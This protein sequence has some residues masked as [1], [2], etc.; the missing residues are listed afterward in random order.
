MRVASSSVL[1]LAAASFA[2]SVA[3]AQ[4]TPPA[5]GGQAPF[6]VPPY[7]NLK[8][9]PQ[10]ITRP[11]LLSNM[12][13]FSQSL[14]VR[15]TYCHVGQEGAPLSTFDFASDAKQHKLIAREMLRMAHRLNTD[16]PGITGDPSAKISCYTCHRGSEKPVSEIPPGT[17]TVPPPPGAAPPPPPAQPAKSERGSA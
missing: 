4:T 5:P 14:G 8:I 10:D 1:V 3:V 7:K 16:L 13:L 12:K 17:N 9:F 6:A 2:V 15:C 11:Q